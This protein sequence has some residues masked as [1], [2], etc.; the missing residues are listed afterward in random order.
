VRG[1]WICDVPAASGAMAKM[2]EFFSRLINQAEKPTGAGSTRLTEPVPDSPMQTA[3]IQDVP[4]VR[5][6]PAVTSL[7]IFSL[8]IPSAVIG[9]LLEVAVTKVMVPVKVKGIRQHVVCFDDKS[10]A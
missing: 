10:K 5:W 1:I 4:T 8:F 7:F 6:D 3:A 9:K 2:P